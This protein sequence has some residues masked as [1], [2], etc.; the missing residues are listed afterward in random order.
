MKKI[1]LLKLIVFVSFLTLVQSPLFSQKIDTIFLNE[2]WQICEKPFASYYRFGKIVID[3]FWRY[4]GRV[5]DFYTS[6]KMEMDGNYSTTGEKNGSFWFFYENGKPKAKGNYQANQRIGTWEYFY[7]DGQLQLR[8]NYTDDPLQFTVLDYID[9]TGKIFMKDGTG[10]FIMDVSNDMGVFIY[11][12][13]GEFR[14]GLKHGT[15]KYFVYIP[16]KNQDFAMIKEVYEKGVLKKGMHI[17][18]FLGQTEN[19][20]VQK[21]PL[22]KIEYAKFRFTEAFAKDRTSFRNIGNDQDLLDYLLTRKAPEYDAEDTTFVASYINVLRTLNNP[23]VIKHFHD[24]H[25]LYNG[26]VIFNLSDSGDIEEIEIN[27]NLTEKEKEYMM[28]FMKKFKN[29]HDITIE[30]V[31]IDAYHKIYFYSAIFAEFLPNKYL[32]YFPK[33]MFMFNGLTYDQLKEQIRESLKK[34]KSKK[35][36]GLP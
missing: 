3:T 24:P 28:F 29:I 21:N 36:K 26:E 20:K 22:T 5:F 6:G 11:R 23:I 8:V 14:E 27:G 19:Y 7:P 9:S 33:K 31:Q 13:E 18:P 17:S 1:H 32:S 15:W 4:T 12:L 25:K 35:E 16:S 10:N 2:K 34:K 30:N